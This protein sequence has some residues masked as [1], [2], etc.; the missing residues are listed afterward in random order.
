MSLE[1]AQRPTVEYYS[2]TKRNNA[3]IQAPRWAD[4]ETLLWEGSQ[5]PERGSIYR[6]WVQGGA[7]EETESRC[8]PA[9]GGG[10]GD[11]DIC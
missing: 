11:G 9:R 3:W 5:A 4:L 7:W 10:R 8:V 2:A 6:R 1:N